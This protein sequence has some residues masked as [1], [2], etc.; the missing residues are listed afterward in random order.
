VDARHP[1]SHLTSA[2]YEEL[3]AYTLTLGDVAFIHQ[4]VVDAFAAQRATEATKPITVAFALIGL[5]LH[6]ERGFTG[7][8]VQ[9]A[10]MMLA[11]RSRSWPIFRLPETRGPLT[12]ADVLAAP[13][14]RE[15]DRAISVWCAAVWSAYAEIAPEVAALARAH[16]L[17]AWAPSE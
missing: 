11:R 3:A 10:H 12:A 9:R 5:Y 2:A 13:A 16:G 7:R 1:G 6:V 4:H 15:R 8:Q 14:G 17:D